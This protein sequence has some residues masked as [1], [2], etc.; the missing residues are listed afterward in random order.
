MSDYRHSKV[1]ELV[2][3]SGSSEVFASLLGYTNL[4]PIAE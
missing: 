3:H 1:R 4:Y 2:A